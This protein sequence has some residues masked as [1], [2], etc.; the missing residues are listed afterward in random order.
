VI[1]AFLRG[2]KE[3]RGPWA[4]LVNFYRRLADARVKYHLVTRAMNGDAH[5]IAQ[6]MSS[7]H[8]SITVPRDRTEA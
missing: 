6:A 7:G 5:M 4:E 8:D 3:I 2:L 1:V